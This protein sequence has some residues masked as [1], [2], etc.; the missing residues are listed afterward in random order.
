MYKILGYLKALASLLG[1]SVTAA[2]GILPPAEYRWLAVV[3]AVCT[4][5]AT[6]AIPNFNVIEPA[7]GKHEA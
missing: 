6:W 7:D 2:L 5:V 4:A 1:A 3:A